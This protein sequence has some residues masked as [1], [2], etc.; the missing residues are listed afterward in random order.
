M[1][2]LEITQLFIHGK[3]CNK[4]FDISSMGESAL[5]SHTKGIFISL[6]LPCVKVKVL[7][8][9]ML[10]KRCLKTAIIVLESPWFCSTTKCMNPAVVIGTECIGSCKSIYHMI[11]T[12]MAPF[13]FDISWKNIKINNIYINN[14]SFFFSLLHVLVLNICIIAVC[15]IFAVFV[16]HIGKIIG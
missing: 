4:S 6:F 15:V 10:R 12:M 9:K 1:P 11:T 13:S 16:P 2:G 3:C 7:Y 5:Q 8:M 14:F